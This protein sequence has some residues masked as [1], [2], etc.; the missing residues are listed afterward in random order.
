MTSFPDSLPCHYSMIQYKW[1]K[2]KTK[3]KNIKEETRIEPRFQAADAFALLS[4]LLFLNGS[5]QTVRRL[6]CI[7]LP[8]FSKR[9][10]CTS[11]SLEPSSRNLELPP[12]FSSSAMATP[13][14]GPRFQVPGSSVCQVCHNQVWMKLGHPS[15]APRSSIAACRVDPFIRT[16]LLL[17]T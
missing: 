11:C 7:E 8:P 16:S 10:C 3:E 2:R 14:T 6:H 17:R 13:E 5:D 9:H 15:F 12:V 4:I 1:H